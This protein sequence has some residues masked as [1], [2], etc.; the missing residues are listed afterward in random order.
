MSAPSSPPPKSARRLER[1]QRAVLGGFV[2]VAAAVIIW[3]VTGSGSTKP[4]YVPTGAGGVATSLPPA[5]PAK[6]P[7]TT[8]AANFHAAPAAT[9]LAAQ[10]PLA[11]QVAQL[12]LV[13]VDG[14]APSAAA[15]GPE[16]WGGVVLDSSNFS[17]DRG[18]AKLV[19]AL[20]SGASRAGHEPMLIAATQEG[21]AQTAFRDLPPQSQAD[22]GTSGTPATAQSQAVA[23]AQAL[24]KLGVNMTLAPLADVDTPQGALTGRLF[25]TDPKAVAQFTA[26]A[27]GGYLSQG[28]ISA[29]G[30]FPGSG[31]AS[32]DPDQM[33]ATVGG[34]LAALEDNDLI[35]F[36]AIVGRAPVIVMSNAAYAA[37]DGVTPASLLPGAVRLLRQGYGFDGAVMSDDLDATLQPTGQTPGQVAL[38]ALQAGDDLLYITGPTAEHQAAYEGVLSAAESQPA[39]RALVRQALLHDLTLKFRYGLVP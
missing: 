13:S 7:G 39:V 25:S 17:T 33:T 34:T 10:L 20:Q 31:S 16:D 18:V 26:A 15:L 35:P 5:T 29:I 4:H 19:S 8:P 38:E 24:K 23:A 21:G 27:L 2:V 28:M 1:W 11:R 3:I 32:A 6:L 36:R 12:F 14:T 9:A 30:H 37:F 22:I